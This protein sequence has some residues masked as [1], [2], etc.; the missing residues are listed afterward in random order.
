MIPETLETIEEKIKNADSIKEED[1][2]ELLKL[3]STMKAEVV[4]LSRTDPEQAESIAGFA[5]V[6][7]H[8]ATRG[9][10]N[11]QLMH[12]SIKGLTS[13]IEGFESTHADLVKIVNSIA[14]IL[15]NMG[16]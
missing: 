10:R 12:L 4:R 15:S 3:L 14:Y 7:M 1:K 9:Q 11:E 8:E 13:S 5:Q 2:Q 16:L 6:S